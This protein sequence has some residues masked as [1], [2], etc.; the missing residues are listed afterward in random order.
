MAFERLLRLMK[1]CPGYVV[2][3][4]RNASVG[5]AT[6][7]QKSFGSQY[8]ITRA[9]FGT[10]SLFAM[11]GPYQKLAVGKMQT[12]TATQTA[13]VF[14]K[15]AIQIR[16]IWLPLSATKV[17]FNWYRFDLTYTLIYK[18]LWR[19]FPW[20]FQN[21]LVLFI[22][23]KLGT[24]PGNCYF[25]I[26]WFFPWNSWQCKQWS[27]DTKTTENTCCHPILNEYFPWLM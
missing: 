25:E 1:K 19:K 24:R 22:F 18:Y 6:V 26:P 12:V 2:S 20:L 8:Y 17:L 15:V 3:R 23:P 14:L 9:L 13:T 10:R 7:T 11:T 5:I 4:L 16:P 27:N 21:V